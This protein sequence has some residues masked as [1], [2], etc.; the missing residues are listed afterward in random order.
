MAPLFTPF[1]HIGRLVHL[2]RELP[3]FPALPDVLTF[4][5]TV[6]LHGTNLG[7]VQENPGA[8]IL[9]Q[10]RN[11]FITPD[12]DNAGAAAFV[13]DREAAFKLIFD[14][15][16]AALPRVSVRFAV[17]GDEVSVSILQDVVLFGELA[18]KGVQKG[19]GITQQDRFVSIFDV[20]VAGKRRAD[21]LET[22]IVP[23]GLEASR[24]WN[25]HRFGRYLVRV[26]KD[27]LDETEADALAAE[28]GRDC[29][30]ARLMGTPGAGEG[31]VWRCF[32]APQA[33][34][35]WFKSKAPQFTLAE[36][37]P[38]RASCPEDQARRD[39]AED[40]AATFATPARMLQGVDEAGRKMGLFV[41]WVVEDVMREEGHD[42]SPRTSVSYRKAVATAAATWF[43]KS[44]PK[45]DHGP[46]GITAE[47]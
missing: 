42:L 44:L 23:P 21:L 46:D 3:Y 25:V 18:G 6:K 33:S 41:K 5:G 28:V 34:R 35:L 14:N 17:N 39:K 22:G 31:I 27:N 36:K 47:V 40:F 10:S 32:D 13:R 7:V 24:I 43:Q 38:V 16:R 2:E 9:V 26:P 8:P 19:V 29:P 1:P 12:A 15:V 30:A 11:R 20:V 37:Q 4:D 45:L